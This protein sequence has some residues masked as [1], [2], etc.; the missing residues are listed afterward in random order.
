MTRRTLLALLIA[1]ALLFPAAVRAQEPA[2][3]VQVLPE[4]ELTVGDP[5]EIRV[6]LSHEAGAQVLMD[7]SIVQMLVPAPDRFHS[8]FRVEFPQ[9]TRQLSH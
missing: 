1:A 6:A 5:V 8:R 7:G 9:Q 2:V 3:E 4:G